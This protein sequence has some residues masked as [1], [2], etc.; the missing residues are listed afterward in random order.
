MNK[1]A[2]LLLFG[3]SLAGPLRAQEVGDEPRLPDLVLTPRNLAALAPDV[4]VTYFR[5]FLK[6]MVHVEEL[7]D[8]S[9]GSKDE[10]KSALFNQIFP[11][12]FAGAE[13]ALENTPCIN[14]MNLSS[15]GVNSRTGQLYCR[16]V[17]SPDCGGGQRGCGQAFM[18]LVPGMG[19]I[20]VPAQGEGTL[21]GRCVEAI[22]DR[23]NANV[24]KQVRR[25]IREGAYTQTV[26]GMKGSLSTLHGRLYGQAS[27]RDYCAGSGSISQ[28]EECKKMGSLVDGFDAGVVGGIKAYD[29]RGKYQDSPESRRRLA[30][31]KTVRQGRRQNPCESHTYSRSAEPGVLFT[32][33][34]CKVRLPRRLLHRSDRV[35]YNDDYPQTPVKPPHNPHH[36]HHPHHPDHPDTPDNP[37]D[38][39]ENESPRDPWFGSP[40]TPAEMEEIQFNR[41]KGSGG[42]GGGSTHGTGNGPGSSGPGS[43]GGGPSG[44]GGEGASGGRSNGGGANGGAGTSH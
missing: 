11:R 23:S 4:Q 9:V 17:P 33:S 38:Q 29:S 19:P 36:P 43:S 31:I 28:R 27:I 32:P 10:E 5:F 34:N 7:Q 37:D 35:R 8:I 12:A 42:G 2:L 14:A 25:A 18:R 22:T 26:G 41:A 24:E 13:S 15:W 21:T 44:G 1:R 39:D 6:Y 20:C 3:L 16:P 40:P 30:N